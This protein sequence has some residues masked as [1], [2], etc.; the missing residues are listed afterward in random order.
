MSLKMER[1]YGFTSNAGSG[2]GPEA[3][4]AEGLFWK[5]PSSLTGSAMVMNLPSTQQGFQQF[6]SPATE[7][8]NTE[9]H[10]LSYNMK[11]DNNYNENKHKINNFGYSESQSAPFCGHRD[12]RMNM[13]TRQ[14]S[15]FD[16]SPPGEP[17]SVTHGAETNSS[18]DSPSVTRQSTL[19]SNIRKMA[20][21]DLN[22]SIESID[23]VQ[24]ISPFRPGY[25]SPRPQARVINVGSYHQNSNYIN[26]EPPE[27]ETFSTPTPVPP[28]PNTSNISHKAVSNNR[29]K[30]SST[31][32]HTLRTELE[33]DYPDDVFEPEMPRNQETPQGNNW[34]NLPGEGDAVTPR[35]RIND[36]SGVDT[37][38]GTADLFN[39]NLGWDYEK[40][41]ERSPKQQMNRPFLQKNKGVDKLW[42]EPDFE[43]FD[44]TETV[45]SAEVNEVSDKEDDDTYRNTVQSGRRRDKLARRSKALKSR[46][47]HP[48]NQVARK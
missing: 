31:L 29:L 23:C 18:L 16:Q 4:P 35:L 38:S 19:V 26:E 5:Q 2:R 47:V 3:A 24:E 28:G 9:A 36:G 17:R 6:N 42:E 41:K 8:I 44:S 40:I 39:Q 12:K 7:Q 27:E 43:K 14:N 33:D 13:S 22:D 32:M 48:I 21:L 37:L 25:Y 46:K 30:K 11:N 15:W 20:E 10:A 1:Y 34:Y 45:N